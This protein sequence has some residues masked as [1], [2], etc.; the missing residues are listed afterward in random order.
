VIVS[1]DERRGNATY[2]QVPWGEFAAVSFVPNLSHRMNWA[3]GLC[4]VALIAGIWTSIAAGSATIVWIVFFILA[5][6]WLYLAT[7]TMVSRRHG[8][9]IPQIF[10]DR[11]SLLEVGLLGCEQ[12][13]WSDLTDFIVY[14]RDDDGSRTHILLAYPAGET[15]PNGDWAKYR[16]AALRLSFPFWQGDQA[17]DEIVHNSIC[18]WLNEWR[19]HVLADGPLPHSHHLLR[20]EGCFHI[21]RLSEVERRHSWQIFA[22]RYPYIRRPAAESQ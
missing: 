19:Q 3:T 6:W 14:G 9:A 22:A 1:V 5:S 21:Q 12:H 7:C 8:V 2:P 10:V 17:R 15:V 13:F 11:H 4:L 18:E 16:E 20:G